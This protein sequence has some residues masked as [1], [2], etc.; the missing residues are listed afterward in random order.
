MGVRDVSLYHPDGSTLAGCSHHGLMNVLP[1]QPKRL[2]A[3]GRSLLCRSHVQASQSTQWG[4][5]TVKRFAPLCLILLVSSCKTTQVIFTLYYTDSISWMPNCVFCSLCCS[6]HG[7]HI[8]SV[9]RFNMLHTYWFIC[10]KQIRK[11]ISGCV[12]QKG[13]QRLPRCRVTPASLLA[14]RGM[15]SRCPCVL[16]WPRRPMVAEMDDSLG[17]GAPPVWQLHPLSLYRTGYLGA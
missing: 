6:A 9:E 16:L 15:G 8:C 13:P 5:A 17:R 14:L 10:V 2:A 4:K 7:E 11:G 1:S 3:A 12:C